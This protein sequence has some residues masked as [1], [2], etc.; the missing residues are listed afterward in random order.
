MK[1]LMIDVDGVLVHGRPSD[2][3]PAMA[4][5][6][7]DLG[8]DLEVLRREFF[9]PHFGEVI[10][11]RRPIE[12]ILAETLARIAP[13]LTAQQLMDYWFANDAR[14]DARLLDDLA[15]LRATGIRMFL[16]T[17]Q[18][19]QRAAYLM[20]N[21][22]LSA[23]VEDAIYSAHVGHRKPEPAFYAH[24]THV[25]GVAPQDIVFLDDIL[26]NIEAAQA[27]GWK[28]VHWTWGQNLTQSLAPHL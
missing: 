15:A 5:L 27:F 17:N 2:G 19:H 6:Q 24:A 4:D 26:E 10:T 8:L 16:A 28:T 20:N 21:L 22:G 3:R 7:Q 11:G 9:I 13:H 23:Y 18:E 12:P 14:L 25:A 1:V